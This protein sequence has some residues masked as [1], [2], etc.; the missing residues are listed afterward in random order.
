MEI[1]IESIEAVMQVGA[2]IVD[3]IGSVSQFNVQEA[4]PITCEICRCEWA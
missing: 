2:M 3:Q 1:G 4:D